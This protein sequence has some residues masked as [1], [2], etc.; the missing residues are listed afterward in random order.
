[1][2]LEQLLCAYGAGKEVCVSD[3][4]SGSHQSLVHHG[5]EYGFFL[6]TILTCKLHIIIELYRCP[7]S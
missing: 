1:M 2:T 3:R 5:R 7:E 6:E 4:S